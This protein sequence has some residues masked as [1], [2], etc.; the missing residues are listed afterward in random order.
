MAVISP[1]PAQAEAHPGLFG[2]RRTPARSGDFSGAEKL[3]LGGQ[4]PMAVLLFLHTRVD[5]NPIYFP[6]LAAVC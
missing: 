3:S 5:R 6:G 2:Q 1:L 4:L